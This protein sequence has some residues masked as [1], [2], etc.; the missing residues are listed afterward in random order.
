MSTPIYRGS[1]ALLTVRRPPPGLRWLDAG[2][3]LVGLTA[4]LFGL[5]LGMASLGKAD[6]TIDSLT[7]VMGSSL[8][9]WRC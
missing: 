4:G 9:Q 1:T 7:G 2:A 5:A 3:L 6:G 8:A